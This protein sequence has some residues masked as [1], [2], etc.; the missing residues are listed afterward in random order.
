[1]APDGNEPIRMEAAREGLCPGMDA[2]GLLKEEERSRKLA[3][4]S[5]IF[6]AIREAVTISIAHKICNCT[7]LSSR[8]IKPMAR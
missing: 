8:C 3:K 1:M 4:T 2:K 5:E 7:E 6:L